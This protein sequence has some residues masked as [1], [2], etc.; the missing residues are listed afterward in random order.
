MNVGDIYKKKIDHNY[1]VEIM[2][3]GYDHYNNEN[4]YHI[5]CIQ[6]SGSVFSN[7]GHIKTEHETSFLSEYELD[8]KTQKEVIIGATY[9][10]VSDKLFTIKALSVNGSFVDYEIL[11]VGN[12]PY[13]TVGFKGSMF[14]QTFLNL[15]KLVDSADIQKNENLNKDQCTCSSRDIFLRGCRCGHFKRNMKNA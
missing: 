4:F 5:K 10:D 12:Y 6:D 2:F 7:V 8:T 11:T 1:K 15:Y 13:S 3:Q 9:Y 14:D